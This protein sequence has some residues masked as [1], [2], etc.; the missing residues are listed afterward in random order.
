MTIKERAK[1]LEKL[2]VQL[3]TDAKA[4]DQGF[5]VKVERGGFSVE[6]EDKWYDEDEEETENDE[7]KTVVV[8]PARAWYSSSVQCAMAGY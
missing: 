1:E 2:I 7:L 4:A 6:F 8:R 5:T 3:I